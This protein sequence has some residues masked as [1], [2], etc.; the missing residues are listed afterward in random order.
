MDAGANYFLQSETGKR[1]QNFSE[2]RGVKSLK[3][4]RASSLFLEQ[5]RVL[6]VKKGNLEFGRCECELSHL[7][8]SRMTLT[9]LPRTRFDFSI[10]LFTSLPGVLGNYLIF[11]MFQE[12]GDIKT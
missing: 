7:L 9:N 5:S 3:N 4:C 6:H 11:Y 12:Q 2:M 10:H 8:F 1:F